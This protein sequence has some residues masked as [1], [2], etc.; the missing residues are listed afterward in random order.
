[1]EPVHRRPSPVLLLVVILAGF[2]VILS[3]SDVGA[4]AL[5]ALGRTPERLAPAPSAP[6]GQG[7]YSYLQTQPGKPADPV[8]YSPCERIEVVVNRDLEPAGAEGLVEEAVARVAGATGLVIAVTGETSERPTENRRTSDRDRYGRGWSPVLVAW[9]SPDETRALE[10]DVV[11]IG[12]SVAVGTGLSRR[13]GYVT[14]SVVLD[15]P[16]AA[17]ILTRVDGRRQLR[18]IVLHE[19]GHLVGLGHVDDPMELM[20]KENTGRFDFGPGD[21]EGLAE[22]GS[23]PCRS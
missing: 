7:P 3:Q 4:S 2:A 13:M 23:G 22:M 20:A 9:S 15:A 6:T 14:G 17:Q 18:A 5:R 12:G 21:L 16:A 11:G 10:G 1:M 19:L 8:T